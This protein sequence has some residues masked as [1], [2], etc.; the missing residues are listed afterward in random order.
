MREES[1]GQ[2]REEGEGG[3]CS[4]AEDGERK[5]LV[6]VAAAAVAALYWAIITI[7]TMGY[8]DPFTSSSS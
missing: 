3:C 4:L 7:T 1:K 8:G 6:V 5:V 2:W